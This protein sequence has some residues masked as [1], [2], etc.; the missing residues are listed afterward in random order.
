LLIDDLILWLTIDLRSAPFNIN[1]KAY[2]GLVKQKLTYY[3]YF[4]NNDQS[5]SCCTGM[6]NRNVSVKFLIWIE[7]QGCPINKYLWWPIRNDRQM[8]TES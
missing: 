5:R 6:G 3:L 4:F 2:S 7:V 8:F 1:S